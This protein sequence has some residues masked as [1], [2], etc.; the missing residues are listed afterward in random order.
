MGSF[1]GVWE[2]ALGKEMFSI[3]KAK[4]KAIAN[5][6]ACLV[7]SSTVQFHPSC[8]KLEPYFRNY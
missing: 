4:H 8:D 5:W 3:G 2:K 7:V 6:L 1:L